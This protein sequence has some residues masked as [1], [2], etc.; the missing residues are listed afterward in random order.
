[1]YFM[2]SVMAIDV[3][4]DSDVL[5]LPEDQVREPE[6]YVVLLLNDDYTTMDF[7][8]AVLMTVFHKNRADSERIMM[9][10]HRK[11]RGLVGIFPF[12]IA[13]TK[14]DQVHALAKANGFPLRCAVEKA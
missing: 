10:V 8:V 13:V 6:N 11:G 3:Q 12:D 9:D 1:M 7:V 14:T 2:A 5:V 4:G